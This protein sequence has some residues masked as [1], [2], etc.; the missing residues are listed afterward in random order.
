MR[1]MARPSRTLPQVTCPG[2]KKPMTPGTPTPIAGSNNLA[3]VRYVCET[4]GTTS[5]R[6]IKL[7]DLAAPRSLGPSGAREN[8]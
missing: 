1:S 7:D 8:E 4:C 3:D 5:V 2:C 6:R